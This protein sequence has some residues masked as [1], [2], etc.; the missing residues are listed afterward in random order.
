MDENENDKRLMK[1]GQSIRPYIRI[2][3]PEYWANHIF[4]LPGILLGFMFDPPKAED[5]FA[6][7]LRILWA[8]ACACLV[9]SSNYVLNE[10]LDAAKDRFHPEKKNRPLA[11]GQASVPVAYVQWL[12]LAAMGFAVAFGQSMALGFTMVAFWISGM[13]YNVP[14]V[15]LKDVPYV[16]VICESLNNPIRLCIGWFAAGG[17]VMPPLSMLFAYWMFGA[18]LMGIKRF[19]EYRH[20]RSSG[21]AANYRNSFAYYTEERLQESIFFYGALFGML[22][23]FFM[24][25]YDAE[26]VLAT[27]LVALAMAYY[28]H[29]GFKENS[30][31]QHPEKLF[32]EKKLMVLVALAF[33]ACA[34]LLYVRMPSFRRAISPWHIP[35]GASAAACPTNSI[36]P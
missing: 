28:I 24:A 16:D 29:L 30:P 8:I 12:V 3:R 33:V 36:V 34:V 31:V 26:I 20:L 21:Q 25:R 2:S 5:A 7:C 22:S 9:A 18:F 11:S 15:R 35:A 32:K 1:L 10:I 17:E 13:I 4:I 27:P 14:P 23:G 19:A 6:L